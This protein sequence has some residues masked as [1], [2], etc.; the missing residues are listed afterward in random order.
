MARSRS[1]RS[2]LPFVVLLGACSVP[3]T[4]VE[5]AADQTVAIVHGNRVGVFS[6]MGL[7]QTVAISICGI[8]GESLPFSG[9]SGYPTE[10]RV[11]PGSHE[12]KVYAQVTVDGTARRSGEGTLRAEFAGGKEYVLSVAS[13]VDGVATFAIAEKTAP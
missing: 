3:G 10:A 12:L 13:I 2:L 5:P 7:G 11:A 4:Y 8:D 1:L 9:S 6:G